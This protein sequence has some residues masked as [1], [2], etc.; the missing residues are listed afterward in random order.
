MLPA[1]C[2]T[3][4]SPLHCNV[5]HSLQEACGVSPLNA[6]ALTCPCPLRARWPYAF[7]GDST[8]RQ[9]LAALL[10][11]IRA[12]APVERIA[13]AILAHTSSSYCRQLPLVSCSVG[14]LAWG[15]TIALGL[16]EGEHESDSDGLSAHLSKSSPIGGCG[17]DD[18]VGLASIRLCWLSTRQ[19][20]SCTFQSWM[21]Q[22]FRV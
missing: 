13:P 15:V 22:P 21:I 4:C 10:A 6:S 5:A 17:E 18:S 11:A 7:S 19:L 9:N 2:S 16:L 1:S 8:R 14:N 3:Q 20:G 12:H